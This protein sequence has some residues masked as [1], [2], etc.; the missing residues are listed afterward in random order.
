MIRI[1]S[2]ALPKSP[3]NLAQGDEVPQIITRRTRQRPPEFLTPPAK[4]L[5][6]HYRVKSRHRY[7]SICDW[8]LM[9]QNTVPK[10][11]AVTHGLTWKNKKQAFPRRPWTGGTAEAHRENGWRRWDR[12]REALQ[13]LFRSCQRPASQLCNGGYR[14]PYTHH[15]MVRVGS[16]DG[17]GGALTLRIWTKAVSPSRW[18]ATPTVI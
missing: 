1:A 15:F 16:L 8:P 6:Q 7:Y 9:A 3:M 13:T 14:T 11:A 2:V 18:G 12:S 10:F 17:V 4:R 5:L